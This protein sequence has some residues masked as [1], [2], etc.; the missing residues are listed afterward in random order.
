[1]LHD[2]S[3]DIDITAKVLDIRI[4][5]MTSESRQRCG[6]TADTIIVFSQRTIN[7]DERYDK[8]FERYD[9]MLEDCVIL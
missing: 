9:K 1:M 4:I 6:N 3:S 2:S 8:M 5:V 7:D